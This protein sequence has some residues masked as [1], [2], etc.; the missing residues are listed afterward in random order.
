MSGNKV[1]EGLVR[2]NCG[3]EN[4]EG[5]RSVVWMLLN[6]FELQWY[7]KQYMFKNF[8]KNYPSIQNIWIYALIV[9]NFKQ[10][11]MEYSVHQFK[12]VFYPSIKEDKSAKVKC[13]KYVS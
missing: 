2:Q 11:A 13:T 10:I 1:Y 5:E 6:K 4:E 8:D 3:H 12:L 7:V 9:A